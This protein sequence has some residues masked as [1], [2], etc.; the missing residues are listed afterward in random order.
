M[1]AL[2]LRRCR[3]SRRLD[4]VLL[5]ARLC[6]TLGSAH[7]DESEDDRNEEPQHVVDP[8]TV[9]QHNHHTIDGIASGD[10]PAGDCEPALD[11]IP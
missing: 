7:H 4:R 11:S 10:L 9:C 6:A 5:Q 1:A 3:C 8:R 2:L